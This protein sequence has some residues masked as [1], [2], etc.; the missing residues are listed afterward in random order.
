M[1]RRG[2]WVALR[3]LDEHGAPAL[4]AKVEVVVAGAARDA[5]VVHASSSYLAS[6][7]PCVHVGIGEAT[8]VDEVVV[9]WGDGVLEVV[10]DVAV[11]AVTVVRRGREE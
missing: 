1:S 11:D 6:N 4:G 7:D 9:I 8:A 10:E 5:R 2:H 3:V